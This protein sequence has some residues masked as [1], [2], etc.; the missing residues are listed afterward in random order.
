MRWSLKI[1]RLAGIDVRVHVTF[2]LLLAWVAF[3][4]YTAQNTVRAALLGVLFTLAVFATVVFHELGHALTARKYGVQTREIILLPIGGVSRLERMP[5][6]PRREF[7]IA[8]AGPLVS[9]AI[10]AILYLA[11]LGFLANPDPGAAWIEGGRFVYRLMWV[12]VALAVFNMVPA[13]PMDGGRVLRSLLAT[14]MP[15]PRATHYAARLG[16]GLAIVLGLAGLFLSPILIF[17]AL[18]VW[19][20]ASQE[21]AEA[22]IRSGLEGFPARAA[23]VI[24][25]QTVAPGEPLSRATELILAGAQEDFPVLEDGRLVGVLT[26]RGLLRALAEGGA[27]QAVVSAME[28]DF[29]TADPSE[30][31][32]DV[33]PRLRMRECQ[34]VP[35]VRDGQLLGLITPEN[36]SDFLSIQAAEAASRERPRPRPRH[37]V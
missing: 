25:F 27:D 17:I 4:E 30:M 26:R 1:A 24:D 3:V 16:Q 33:L 2:L 37:A 9:L 36:V 10:A 8:A 22:Q 6:D 32:S 23:M 5:E 29:E 19:L 34:T 11:Y 13:F 15:Y 14:R 31:L 28:R 21:G 12:N 7:W 20:G 35:V 18:F